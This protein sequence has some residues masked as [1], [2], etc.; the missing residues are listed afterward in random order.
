MLPVVTYQTIDQALDFINARPRPLALYLFE[1]DR[2][3]IGHVM[4]QTVAGG[5]T[6]GERSWIGAGATVIQQIEIGAD[7][8]VGAGSVVIRNVPWGSTVV[9]VPAA[10]IHR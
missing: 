10:P 1:R 7:V 6:V 4:R 9:G 5:V 8:T 2:H 3:T